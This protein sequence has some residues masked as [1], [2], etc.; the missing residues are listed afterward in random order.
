MP[1]ANKHDP[2]AVVYYRYDPNATQDPKDVHGGLYYVHNCVALEEL[3]TKD[4]LAH[5]SHVAEWPTPKH[6][7]IC[8]TK[9]CVEE[10]VKASKG[11]K[12]KGSEVS[13]D[14]WR[15]WVWV[16]IHR[17]GHNEY[18]DKIDRQPIAWM[19]DNKLKDPHNGVFD[20]FE[21]KGKVCILHY[22]H[23]VNKP[24]GAGEDERTAKKA[25]KF[26]LQEGSDTSATGNIKIATQAL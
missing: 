20:S 7:Y 6:V 24:Y 5:I 12:Y 11:G 4:D 26:T 16:A 22:W 9:K 1:D 10:A 17:Y 2:V 8:G 13:P 15:P 14:P 25:D 19:V 3:P 21:R 23:Y 18:P